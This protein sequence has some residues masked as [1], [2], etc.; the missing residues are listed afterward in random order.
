MEIGTNIVLTIVGLLLLCFGGYALVSGGVAIAKKFRISSLLI[1]LTIVAYGTSTPELAVSVS[2]ALVG[3]TNL[4]LGNVIGSNIANIGMVIGISAIVAPLLITKG[5]LIMDN[6]TIKIWIPIML[7][8]SAL[9]VIL[10]IIEKNNVSR[11]SGYLFIVILI[12]LS[13]FT[14]Y[15]AKKQR[16]EKDVPIEKPLDE[17]TEE[18]KINVI[19]KEKEIWAL[20]KS[21][22]E[23]I[24]GDLVG[25]Y[26]TVERKVDKIPPIVLIIIGAVALCGGGIFTIN[27][28]IGIAESLDISTT[29]I[30]IVIIAIGTS[31]PELITSIIALRKGQANI[32][33]GNIIGS[34]IY[35]IL[36]ILGVSSIIAGNLSTASLFGPTQ[37]QNLIPNDFVLMIVFSTIILFFLLWNKIPFITKWRGKKYVGTIPWGGGIIL[38]IMYTIYLIRTSLGIA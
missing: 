3:E 20:P 29:V 4:I 17:E 25:Y 23:N 8:V 1:G 5:R 21:P 35:N 11:E 7:G 31:L 22:F 9:L 26:E 16:H 19:K 10:T 30:G 37:G 27:G 13:F 33:I 6:N 24:H 12:G 2:S 15:R 14:F 38:V 36:L 34:N 28:S 32:G 18:P